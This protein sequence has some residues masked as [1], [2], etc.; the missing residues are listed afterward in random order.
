[1]MRW[2]YVARE[3]LSALS[4]RGV[5]SMTRS[6]ADLRFHLE[7]ATAEYIRE[8]LSPDDARARP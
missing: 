4:S 2:F 1:M 5:S 7:Q 8:G 6:N 3:R